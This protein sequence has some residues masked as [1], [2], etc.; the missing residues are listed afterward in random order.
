MDESMVTCTACKE[1]NSNNT[2]YCSNCGQEFQK[3]FPEDKYDAFISYR[4]SGGAELAWLI[5]LM[6]KELFKRDIF[7][8]VCGL[9]RGRFDD[10]LRNAIANSANFVLILSPG[11][12]DRCSMDGDWIL[13]EVREA[14]S[15]GKTIIQVFK[16][17]FVYP[18]TNDIPVELRDLPRMQ[19]VKY[20]HEDAFG[21]IRR[22]FSY[23]NEDV[24]DNFAE[25]AQTD[26][27]ESD[28]LD[29]S[30]ADAIDTGERGQDSA[31]NTKFARIRFNT[32]ESFIQNLEQ[33]YNAGKVA[34]NH[35]SK[36]VLDILKDIYVFVAEEHI[37]PDGNSD[38]TRVIL[39]PRE[40][41]LNSET[42]F[43]EK[44]QKKV[45]A[46]IHIVNRYTVG[47][48]LQNSGN[49]QIHMES[50]SGFTDE[51][52]RQLTEAH[53]EFFEKALLKRQQAGKE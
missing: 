25:H 2:K 7:L 51:V 41:T 34:S 46:Y 18:D 43:L 14:K 44:A 3:E 33:R 1:V 13:E 30:D 45:Y 32:F 19:G 38:N 22:I 15:R 29:E 40:M 6:G 28:Q 20:N 31:E 42:A 47:I 35:I 10:G 26:L 9:G 39:T 8:D 5:K 49:Y 12:L 37:F 27:L 23:F 17:G 21:S 16:D 48:D 36:T 4:R 52:K 24:N 53:R 50:R 11:A